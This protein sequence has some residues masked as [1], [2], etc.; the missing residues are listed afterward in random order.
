MIKDYRKYLEPDYGEVA[1]EVCI[2]A[3]EMIDLK[4]PALWRAKA[5][6]ETIA[7]LTAL[8]KPCF[9][10]EPIMTV[11]TTNHIM[12]RDGADIPV[13]VYHPEGEGPFPIMVFYHGG[14]FSMNNLDIYDYVPRYMAKYGNIA[15]AAVEYRL[16]PE[17]KFPTGLEDAYSALEWAV[18][19]AASYHGDISSVSVCG[20][21]AGG[22]FAAAV[23]LMSR[24]RK[25]PEIHKQIM[26][27]PLT[28]FKPD[29]RTESELRYGTGYFI[30]LDS[31]SDAVSKALS[32]YF[33]NTDDM[34]HP[35]ASPL[36]A[37]T[38]KGLPPACFISAE[39]D[40]ILDQGLIYA[41]R[42]EDEGVPVEYHIYKG[43]IH[44]FLNRTYG[45]TFEALNDIC[46][47]IPRSNS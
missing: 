5:N 37:E 20:D 6:Y 47:C 21:S 15:I 8:I 24:D 31:Q 11:R 32:Y 13:R 1:P 41:A 33:D 10:Y 35:Y 12:K 7:A 28:I 40:P 22:N 17:N 43:M 46:A 2:P 30:E 44:G 16:A 4:N 39:C 9:C 3:P 36:C 23:S 42:L 45:K 34:Y 26:I 38:L 14:G 25:G 18:E 29:R 19:N 27:Y